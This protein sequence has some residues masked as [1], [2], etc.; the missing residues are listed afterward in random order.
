MSGGLLPLFTNVNPTPLWDDSTGVVST[1]SVA[2]VSSLT[3]STITAGTVTA[4]YVQSAID[5]SAVFYTSSLS[6]TAPT[7]ASTLLYSLNP[8]GGVSITGTYMTNVNLVTSAV[9]A[10]PLT[11]VFTVGLSGNGSVAV[12][13]PLVNNNSGT[14]DVSPVVAGNVVNVYLANNGGLS[15]PYLGAYTRIGF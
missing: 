5:R 14:Y 7:V 12:A 6:G 4:A 11:S 10:A 15:P 1:F 3:A 2:S 13:N 8:A 9:N